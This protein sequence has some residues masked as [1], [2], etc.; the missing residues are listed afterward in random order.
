MPKKLGLGIAFFLCP[1]NRKYEFGLRQSLAKPRSFD[2]VQIHI[3][4]PTAV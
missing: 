4:K 2:A 3:F 1:Q